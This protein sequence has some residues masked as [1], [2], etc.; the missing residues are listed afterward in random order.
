[1]VSGEMNNLNMQVGIPLS[2]NV[3][4]LAKIKVFYKNGYAP[5]T[6]C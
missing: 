5:K 4:E 3:A 6:A 1:M 2:L